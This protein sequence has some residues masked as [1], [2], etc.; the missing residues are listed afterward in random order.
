[1]TASAVGTSVS[2][3]DASTRRGKPAASADNVAALAVARKSRLVSALT[4]FT[5]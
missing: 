3:A 2:A 5:I 4:Q 1:M